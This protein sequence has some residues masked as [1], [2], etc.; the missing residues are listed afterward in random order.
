MR[1]PFHDGTARRGDQFRLSRKRPLELFLH[2]LYGVPHPFLPRN[3][4]F[5]DACDAHFGLSPIRRHQKALGTAPPRSADADHVDP[6]EYNQFLADRIGLYVL[7]VQLL[8]S[9]RDLRRT[10]RRC[11]YGAC[12]F[13]LRDTAGAVLSAGVY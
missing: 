7:Q 12:V 1:I 11:D 5:F 2:L 13:A 10:S 8:L 4:A 6:R 9:P 3:D